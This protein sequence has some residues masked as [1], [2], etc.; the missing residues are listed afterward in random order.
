MRSADICLRQHLEF[1][2]CRLPRGDGNVF[3]KVY[4]SKSH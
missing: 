2:A 3:A 1:G 4:T